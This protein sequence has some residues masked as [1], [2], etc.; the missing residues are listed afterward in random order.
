MVK[1]KKSDRTVA[2]SKVVLP[3]YCPKCRNPLT[4]K[5]F[6]AEEMFYQCPNC[7][8]RKDLSPRQVR[9][10][11]MKLG[12]RYGALVNK[13]YSQGLNVR[14]RRELGHLRSLLDKM[15][16]PFYRPII[17]NLEKLIKKM[18]K[19]AQEGK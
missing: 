8:Y 5:E 7:K 15:D 9:N 10:E 4:V 2:K 1:P 18:E 13:K 16:A 3:G 12:Q 17:A 6:H 14:E 11:Q 19:L